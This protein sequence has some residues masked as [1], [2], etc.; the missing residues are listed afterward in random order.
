[1]C[2]DLVLADFTF[3]LCFSFVILIVA[4]LKLMER[5]LDNFSCGNV[6]A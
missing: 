3:S 2:G 5:E 6:T 4:L 1:M